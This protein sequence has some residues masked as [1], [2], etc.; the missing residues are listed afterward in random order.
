MLSRLGFG[1]LRGN[2]YDT[3][4]RS[5]LCFH[6][7]GSDGWWIRDVWVPGLVAWICMGFANFDPF[8]SYL[9]T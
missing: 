3:S 6:D 1:E 8:D 4:R 2:Y 5:S 9:L 7:N